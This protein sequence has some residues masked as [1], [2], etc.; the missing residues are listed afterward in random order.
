MI[1][2]VNALLFGAGFLFAYLLFRNPDGRSLH[3]QKKVSF[4]PLDTLQLERYPDE[5]AKIGWKVSKKDVLA[6]ISIAIAATLLLALLTSN[7]FIL[8]AGMAASFYLPKFLIE[9]KRRSGKMALLSK[10]TDPLRM[11]LSRLP[12]QP[13]ITRAIEA[14]RDET[15]DE[16]IRTLFTDYIADTKSGTGVRDALLNM[17]NKVGLKKFDVFVDHLIQMQYEGFTSD[18]IKALDKAVEA[19]EFDLR[20]IEKV[21][22]AS[23]N[24]KRQLYS[25]L[26]V[27][28][29]FPPILSFVHTGNTNI[30]L[31]TI[32]GQILMFLYFLGSLYVFTRGEEYLSL[33]LDEL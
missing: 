27:T 12:E 4:A 21:K 5:A 32:A 19:I 16:R 22:E 25:A 10:L 6:I 11:L 14:T 13:N 31:N 29:L 7:P 18:A 15:A 8:L 23:K 24:K 28:W 30:Y 1:S 33:N 17:K 3:R 2:L 9:Q 26:G 20:A